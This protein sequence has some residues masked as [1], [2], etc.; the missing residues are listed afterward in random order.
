MPNKTLQL[1]WIKNE[2][3]NEWFDFLKLN[4]NSSYFIGKLGIY[5]IWYTSSV[6]GVSKVIRLGQ[7]NI[8]ERLTEHR[9]NP[10]I[11]NYSSLGTLKVTWALVGYN[12]LT[13]LNLD[14]VEAYLAKIYE[15][16]IGDRFPTAGR[17]PV[18]PI[19]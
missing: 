16:L 18:N 2:Q 15:P 11:L 17:I 7:G 5:V 3:N 1:Q 13:E 12:D 6:S 14:G 8:G 19:Q 10:A 4:L 9:N